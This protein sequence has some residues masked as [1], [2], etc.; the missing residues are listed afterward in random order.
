M[1]ETVDSTGQ[2]QR[3][4][5][6]VRP[7]L[8][9]DRCRLAIELV[10]GS[11]RGTWQLG[12]GQLPRMGIA[13][14]FFWAVGQGG[15]CW[16]VLPVVPTCQQTRA[17]HSQ[18]AQ[19]KVLSLGSTG[20]QV[21]TLQRTLN[22]RLKPSPGLS[23]DGDFG[24]ATRLA[25]IR[26]QESRQLKNDGV[27]DHDDW[28]AMGTPVKPDDSVP[29]PTA[30][31][32]QA[33]PI[34]PSDALEGPPF[35]TAKS[36]AIAD[37]E[38]GKILDHL[39]KDKVLDIA[40]TTKIMTGLLVLEFAEQQPTVLQEKI[41]FSSKADKTR[42]STSG[43]RA[44]ETI[45][46]K[47]LLYGLLLPSGNDASVAF[48]EH[49]GTRMI[50]AQGQNRPKDTGYVL[51]VEAMNRRAR[52]LGMKNTVFKNPHGLTAAGHS[53][54]AADLVLLAT[55]AMKLSSFRAYVSTRQYGCK[56]G[57]SLGGNRNIAWKNT[58]QLLGIEGYIGIKTGTTAAA[59]ACLVSASRRGDKELVMVVL[60]SGS[61]RG[62]YVD[63]RNLYRWAWRQQELLR[64]P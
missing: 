51:F 27:V 39:S 45:S 10:L 30:F 40:S 42:G 35:V 12:E 37:L 28:T 13:L 54:T 16:A 4:A 34:A 47:E 24:P 43:L 1:V 46:V 41:T 60:G 17:E 33:L 58:N 31:N 48:A 57:T 20:I 59:G 61:S 21:E 2:H 18:P 49:F 5:I 8:L 32:Q 14:V 26:F 63:T 56:V 3:K 9:K 64:R 7:E 55:A 15:D 23:V 38:T 29:D 22:V 52:R 19:R 44:G 11:A 36:W 6:T 53:S 25:V 62:R 50:E